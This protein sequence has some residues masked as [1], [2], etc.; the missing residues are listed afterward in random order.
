MGFDSCHCTLKIQESIWDSNSQHG[1]SLGSVSVHSLTLF[2]TPESMWC[3]SWVFPLARN[4]TTLCFG[5]EPKA[6]VATF[7]IGGLNRLSLVKWL[8][9][10]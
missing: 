2:G 9:L 1:S 8:R 3:D 4:L 7:E 5:R 10:V 6:R